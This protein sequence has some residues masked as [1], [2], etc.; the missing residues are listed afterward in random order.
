M[1]VNGFMHMLEFTQIVVVNMEGNT[2][3]KILRP[4]GPTMSIHGDYGQ[5]CLCIA[6]IFDRSDLSI[7]ILKDYGTSKWT[8]K[9][10]VNML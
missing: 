5:L 2:W 7:R 9:H 1:F 6:D 4:P 10:M 3:R 8:L